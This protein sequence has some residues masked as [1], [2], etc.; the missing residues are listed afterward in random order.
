M[1]SASLANSGTLDIGDGTQ[2]TTDSVSAASLINSATI[3]LV[4]NGAARATLA[5]SGTLTNNDAVTITNDVEKL[6][7][8]IS[9]TGSFTLDGKSRLQFDST[10]GSSTTINSQNIDFAGS[11]ERLI[12][13]DP[14]G[15]WGEISGFAP[16]DTVALLG[17]WAFSSF[18]EVSGIG[19]LTLKHGLTK[20]TFDFVS[21]FTASNFHI[22]T[23]ATTAITT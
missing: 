2:T 7:G 13:E 11:G 8:A 4:G 23:G 12:L 20:H 16:R 1:A 10:V 18:A 6:G 17:K 21:N 19:E 15:F 3:N 5:L 14:K 9:G 22:V